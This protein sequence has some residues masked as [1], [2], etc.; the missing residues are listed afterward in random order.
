[1]VNRHRGEVE[2]EL[3]GRRYTLCLTLGALA[4]IEHAY[5][6][7]DLLAIAE[8]FEQGRIKATDAIRVIGAGL[9][10]A[11]QEITDA[12]VANMQVDGGAAGYLR[13]VADLLKATFAVED[14]P[15][16]KNPMALLGQISPGSA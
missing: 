15:P 4:E 3:G 12:T 16:P 9:R 2:A 6:G 8:R 14:A 10:G 11:G 1:M 5:G 13:I 7:E